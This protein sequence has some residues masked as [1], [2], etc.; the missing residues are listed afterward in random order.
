MIFESEK[1]IIPSEYALFFCFC[2][3]NDYIFVSDF[4][5][6]IFKG[7]NFCN[8]L[9]EVST[10]R[11]KALFV[12]IRM[13]IGVLYLMNAPYPPFTV[14]LQTCRVNCQYRHVSF[15]GARIKWF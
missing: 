5:S 13:C 15:L 12:I 7:Y 2:F 1:I 14:A 9:R 10:A 4:F 6:I 11:T 3:Q 8:V